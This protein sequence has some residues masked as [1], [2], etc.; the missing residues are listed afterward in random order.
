M[1]RFMGMG[2]ATLCLV[3]CGGDDTPTHASGGTSSAGAAGA[4][5]LASVGGAGGSFS[6]GSGGSAGTAGADSIEV[7]PLTGPFGYVQIS[8]GIYRCGT[9]RPGGAPRTLMD[10]NFAN[11]P[12]SVPL[13]PLTL[14]YRVEAL[15][16]E[17]ETLGACRVARCNKDHEGPLT[18]PTAGQVSVGEFMLN[19]NSNGTYS[20]EGRPLDSI[21][22]P[23]TV[24][25]VSAEGATVGAFSGSVTMPSKLDVTQPALPDNGLRLP[26]DED[27]T[28]TWNDDGTGGKAFINLW[29]L[30]SNTTVDCAFDAPAGSG[31]IEAELLAS[32]ALQAEG[33]LTVGKRQYQSVMAGDYAVMISALNLPVE[34]YSVIFQ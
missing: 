27:F 24:I 7:E 28:V 31:T 8:S 18:F 23:G 11:A 5:G 12:S 17:I 29:Q 15:D 20:P 32:F 22:P 19:P 3:A 25:P 33:L 10:P 34:Y 9:C 1:L 14:P 26:I 4:G 13:E 30:D 21:F 2:M 6:G 16:C